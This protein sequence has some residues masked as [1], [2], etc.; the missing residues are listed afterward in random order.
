LLNPRVAFAGLLLL[1]GS[2]SSTP[3]NT[4]N[5][6][7]WM[8]IIFLAF[9]VIVY[10]ILRRTRLVLSA[11]GVQLFQ[12]GYKLETGCPLRML[13]F[14]RGGIYFNS[15]IQMLAVISAYSKA[16]WLPSGDHAG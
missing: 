12:F 11:D 7:M 1:A 10:L 9:A 15:I 4:R 5:L 6:A 16:I 8:G 14:W 3:A 13:G 2:D